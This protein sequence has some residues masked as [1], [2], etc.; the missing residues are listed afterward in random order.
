MKGLNIATIIVGAW[1]VVDTNGLPEACSIIRLVNTSQS[2][3]LISFDG[4]DAHDYSDP[5]L[6]PIV[7]LLQMNK[8]HHSKVCRMAKGTKIYAFGAVSP[9]FLYVVGYY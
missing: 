2:D 8:Q 7:L 9:G 6:I 5:E 3:L 4:I 1:N